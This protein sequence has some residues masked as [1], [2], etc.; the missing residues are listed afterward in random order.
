MRRSIVLPVLLLSS[1]S[2]SA[3]EEP[4]QTAALRIGD[5]APPVSVSDWIRAP[6]NAPP[7]IEPGDGRIYVIDFW[8]TWCGPCIA[9]FPEITE[10]Q[11]RFAD[12]GVVFVG[13]SDERASVVERFLA[14][15]LGDE[16]RTQ[17]DRIDYAIATD[18]DNSTHEAY[19]L[20]A[21]PYVIPRAFVVGRAG[22]VEWI[23]HPSVDD[24]EG[25]LQ[26]I[27]A[28][29]PE[30]AAWRA[31]FEGG[32]QEEA[33]FEDL[34]AQEHW[35]QAER[36]AGDDW[37]RLNA[38]AWRIAFDPAGR[39]ENRD[40]A[41]AERLAR[42]AVALSEESEVFPFHALAL[43]RFERGDPEEAVALQRKA[44][45]LDTEGQ[46]GPYIRQALEN[47]ERAL[48]ASKKGADEG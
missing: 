27:I 31:R 26:K 13:L 9:G 38:I 36:F 4:A 34:L 35:A 19:L 45:A 39:I 23:G 7:R 20:A 8:A 33:F 25:A 11:E 42:R 37:M 5:A 2:A 17:G 10:M 12:E 29:E 41:L 15:P 3:Q 1:V 21:G 6:E 46:G 14:Q 18:P 32:E 47:Y 43:I 48:A 22:V 40:L 44:V 28:G 16:G 24:L 30:R